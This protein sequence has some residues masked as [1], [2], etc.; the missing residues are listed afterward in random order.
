MNMGFLLLEIKKKRLSSLYAGG[1][2]TSSWGVLF[3]CLFV[4][5]YIRGAD[6]FQMCTVRGFEAAFLCHA[7]TL[8][9]RILLQIGPTSVKLQF[10]FVPRYLKMAWRFKMENAWHRHDITTPSPSQP[11]PFLG[12]P[13]DVLAVCI[14]SKLL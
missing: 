2:F 12:F 5:P 14:G 8:I 4:V 11:P 13:H 1:P 6:E 7:F 3:T 9:K 10:S